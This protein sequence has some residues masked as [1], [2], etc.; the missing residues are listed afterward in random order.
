[1]EEISELKKNIV[2]K[3]EEKRI[4]WFDIEEFLRQKY[5]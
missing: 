4:K 2:T 5:P 1:M 3:A